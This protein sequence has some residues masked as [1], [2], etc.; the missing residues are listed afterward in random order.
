MDNHEHS[1][2]TDI[3]HAAQC[4]LLDI[5]GTLVDSNDFHVRAWE[6]AFE[7]CGHAVSASA[8]RE[9]IGKGGDQLVPALLP[10]VTPEESESIAG[11][12]D[13]IF[14][15]EYLDEVRPFE[16]ATDL[17]AHL[18]EAG[19]K[20]VLASSSKRVEV[21]HYIQLLQLEKLIDAST[22]AD[23]VENSKPAGDLFAAA[24]KKIGSVTPAQARVIGDTPY[25][26]I[27]A[28]KCGVETI[29]VL[30]GGFAEPALRS[31]GARM[32]YRDVGEIL[33]QSERSRR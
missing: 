5:D 27:A 26:A 31:A 2:T 28:A 15:S 20:V 9:Q 1:M 6:R 33:A 24:L 32:I 21:D 8:I 19:I 22:C 4:V 23:D 7:R 18:H 10:Q 12:H 29:A 3:F 30:S 25:D 13:E 11:A 16:R 14:Q 17:V